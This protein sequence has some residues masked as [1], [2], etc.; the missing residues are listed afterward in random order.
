MLPAF[1][2]IGAAVVAKAATVAY[3]AGIATSP[4]HEHARTELLDNAEQILESL[5]SSRTMHEGH[6]TKQLRGYITLLREHAAEGWQE[7]GLYATASKVFNFV[8][9]A[10]V[11]GTASGVASLVY[12]SGAALMDGCSGALDRWLESGRSDKKDFGD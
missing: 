10:H 1:V 9:A 4:T 8:L 11:R 6:R 3:L 12:N 2:V 7:P 5:V